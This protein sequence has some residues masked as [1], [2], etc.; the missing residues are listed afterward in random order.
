MS[1]INEAV[2]EKL[3]NISPVVNEKVVDLLVDK[4]VNRRVELITQGL[5]KL[6]EAERETRKLSKPN[7]ETF[8][9]DGSVATTAFTKD[10]LDALNKHNEKTEKLRKALDKAVDSG[11]IGD[12][13]NLVK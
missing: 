10:A 12:L 9:A 5:A 2:A 6:N 8:N 13:T 7:A 4:E 11:D 1:S 3:A